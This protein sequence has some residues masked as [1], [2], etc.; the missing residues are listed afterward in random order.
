ML[1][2][3]RNWGAPT[4][5]NEVR[6]REPFGTMTQGP[7]KRDVDLV[8]SKDPGKQKV[9]FQATSKTSYRDD[10]IQGPNGQ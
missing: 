7:G 4:G 9:K 6:S 5:T 1:L 8:A 3:S 2:L 10:F